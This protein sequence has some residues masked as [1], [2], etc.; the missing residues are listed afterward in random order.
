MLQ[1]KLIKTLRTMKTNSILIT[2]LLF[3]SFTINAQQW[4]GSNN[5][6]AD[7]SR[8]GNIGIGT[9][10]LNGKL[11]VAGNVNIGG[12]A[13]Y[14][15]KVRTI[16]GK[17]NTSVAIDHLYLNS[18]TGKNVYVGSGPLASDLYVGRSLITGNDVTTGGNILVGGNSN[19]YI[20]T[21]HLYGKSSTTSLTD[22]LYLNYNTGKN[23]YIGSGPTKSNL[24]VG[25]NITTGNDITTGGNIVVGGSSNRNIKTRH[26]N[27]KAHNGTA[28]DNLYI[29]YNTGKPVFIGGV[30]K[31]NL[32]VNGETYVNGGWLRVIGNK[33]IYFQNHGGGFYM[34]DKTWIRTYGNKSFYHRSG[35]MRTDGALQAGPYGNRFLVKT[36]GN[37][38][39]NT[40][41]PDYKLDV[42]GVIRAKEVRVETG[43]SDHVFLP[44][45]EL[46][47][48]KE[49][50]EFIK[51]NGH[52]LG[53]ESEK[54]M[55]G[56][57]QL[58]DV[59]NRQQEAIEKLMLHVIELDKKYE[60]L[61]AENQRL[62]DDNQ[63]LKTAI[64]NIQK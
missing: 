49:E 14:A 28:I 13:N 8:G 29:N 6:A 25:G 36:D 23:V 2:I 20:K 63:H 4:A 59:T 58:A 1:L 30:Q 7:I 12:T 62:K 27:G 53:F 21:R 52:L 31:S 54:D 33:G 32:Y 17:S 47:T 60:Q 48:L 56:E 44:E 61:Q 34:V 39:I 11:T 26:L 16:Q 38:G 15:L 18:N 3:L 51:E 50:G 43:W 9:S 35:V 57:V 64:E 41:T 40:T 10:A 5:Q 55:G 19:R 45:Y 42:N 22:H 46:P 24:Y 37:V